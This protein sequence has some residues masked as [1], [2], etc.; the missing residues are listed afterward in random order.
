MAIVI[1][2]NSDTYKLTDMSL[3]SLQKAVG[4]NIELVYNNV[5]TRCLVNEDGI[6]LNLAVNKIASILMGQMLIGPVIVL[7][8]HEFRETE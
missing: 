1:K 8:E 2:E 6:G 5:R 7:A 3:E 4:G